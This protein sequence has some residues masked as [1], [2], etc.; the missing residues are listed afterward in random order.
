MLDNIHTP[1]DHI[2]RILE[3]FS[4]RYKTKYLKGQAEHGGRLWRKSTRD[5]LI[6]ETLDFISY[7]DCIEEQTNEA[8]RFLI[9]GRVNK[10]WTAIEAAL[11]LLLVGNEDGVPEDDH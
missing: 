11:N 9:K 10:D 1:E 4:K 7:V 2:E 8:I 6:E 5:A 3:K